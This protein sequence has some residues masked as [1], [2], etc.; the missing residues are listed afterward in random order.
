[1]ETPPNAISN[2]G[3]GE[4]PKAPDGGDAPIEPRLAIEGLGAE[5][6]RALIA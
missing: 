3:A 5:A 4:G 6:R 2:D 1:M